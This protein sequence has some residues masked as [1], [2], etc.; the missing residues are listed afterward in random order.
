MC[1]AKVQAAEKRLKA[2]EEQNTLLHA[3]LAASAEQP[4]AAEGDGPTI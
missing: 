2:V 3:Q 1:E 4:G